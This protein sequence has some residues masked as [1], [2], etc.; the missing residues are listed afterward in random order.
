MDEFDFTNAV[1][2]PFAEKIKKDGYKII[3]HHSAAD[4]DWDEVI[5]VNPDETA[6]VNEDAARTIAG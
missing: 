5:E 1:K 4:G 2:N 6:I 3:V